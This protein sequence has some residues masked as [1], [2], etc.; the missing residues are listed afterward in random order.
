MHH[1]VLT[2]RGIEPNLQ[3][4]IMMFKWYLLSVALIGTILTVS[5]LVCDD[6]VEVTTGTCADLLTNLEKALLQDK[7]NLFRLRRAFFHSPTADPVLLKVVYNVTYAEN[8]TTA[9]ADDEIQPCSASPANSST[10]LQQQNV[11]LGWTS[12]GVYVVFHPTVLNMIQA[13]LPFAILRIIHAIMQQRSPEA[14]TFLWDGF[15]DLP[16]LHLNMY[17][18]SLSCIPSQDLFESVLIDLNT[19]VSDQQFPHCMQ[20]A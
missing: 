19:L 2:V 5:C 4:C 8:I 14:D 20:N 10:E 12:T 9:F 1:Y 18:V 11:T 7:G 16:T 13:Q 6:P 15:Y 3:L 17:I